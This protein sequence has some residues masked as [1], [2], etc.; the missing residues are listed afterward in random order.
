MAKKSDIEIDLSVKGLAAVKAA[1][2]GVSKG[3][4]DAGKKVERAT[5]DTEKGFISLRGTISRTTMGIGAMG[6]ALRAVSTIGVAGVV[7]GAAAVTAAYVKA[8]DEIS[9]T[10]KRIMDLD[11]A[12]QN[13]GER[14]FQALGGIRFAVQSLGGTA[15]QADAAMA[16]LRETALKAKDGD[17][18]AQ[19]SLA[20]I[21]THWEDIIDFGGELRGPVDIV[22][23]LAE[24]WQGV[25]GG[26]EASDAARELFGDGYA[27]MTRLLDMGT[28]NI[29]GQIE[30]Y[31]K[32]TGLRQSD[33]VAAEAHVRQLTDQQYAIEGLK[34]AFFRGSTLNTLES[35][36]MRLD[37]L[38]EGKE[39]AERLG[40]AM[41]RLSLTSTPALITGLENL[42]TAAEEALAFANTGETDAA[43][44]QATIYG[45][46]QAEAAA[47]KVGE[48][49]IWMRDS[50]REAVDYAQNHV[51]PILGTTLSGAL[52]DVIGLISTGE[53]DAPWLSTIVEDVK[54]FLEYLDRT[55]GVLKGVSDA[56]FGLAEDVAAM[57]NGAFGTDLSATEVVVGMVL[58]SSTIG[59]VLGVMSKLKGVVSGTWELISKM[60]TGVGQLDKAAAVSDALNGKKGAW[61]N[62]RNA[63]AVGTKLAVGAGAVALTAAA[64]TSTTGLDEQMKEMAPRVN[65]LAAEHG[66]EYA[67]AYMIAFLE[68]VPDEFKTAGWINSAFNMV[69][70]GPDF[71]QAV[72]DAE[73]IIAAGGEAASET[74]RAGFI[75][76]FRDY[77]WGIDPDGSLDIAAGISISGAELS[78]GVLADLGAI[79]ATI[80]VSQVA[81]LDD[82]INGALAN[83]A[84][85]A[86]PAPF[87]PGAAAGLGM[88]PGAGLAPVT[89]NIGTTSVGGLYGSPDAIS[90]LERAAH[91][92][93][94]GRV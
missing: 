92:T 56:V 64:V 72:T 76:A 46:G 24:S 12:A 68:R 50:Y 10:A 52:G 28:E 65:A 51:I 8:K 42:A 36:D 16:K 70:L 14:D 82:A 48:A 44:I 53:T 61:T 6:R 15:E 29:E 90:Q 21:G 27:S 22:R 26:I 81:G 1:F 5:A 23:K 45:L 69:G 94:R 66:E 41:S 55:L 71:E 11:L 32:L 37:G 9:E 77:G 78:A 38:V 59:T 43:W 87:D 83:L 47:I 84:A 60:I 93:K 73:G 85:S 88:T 30:Q 7:G 67:A 62:G 40:E 57:I 74:V 4:V 35:R 80:N 18:E 31:D 13:L 79:D 34:N 20:K 3:G 75:Q 39:Q 91:M 2:S 54:V 19:D 86:A 63:A 25:K 33:A 17:E 89:I 49:A 58:F